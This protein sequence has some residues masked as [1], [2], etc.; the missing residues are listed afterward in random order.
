M[1]KS[2]VGADSEAASA[3][4]RATR[5]AVRYWIALILVALAAIS[6]WASWSVSCFVDAV[7]RDHA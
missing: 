4:R 1:A 3:G 6:S 2:D 5:F 7:G